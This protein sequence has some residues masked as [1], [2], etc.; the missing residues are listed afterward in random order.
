MQDMTYTI[1]TDL[2]SNNKSLFGIPKLN[3]DQEYAKLLDSIQKTALSSAKDTQE[4]IDNGR[5]T[6]E[7]GQP[8][9]ENSFAL[10]KKITDERDEI[11]KKHD[12]YI[13]PYSIEC[14]E[15]NN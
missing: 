4:L 6:P 2:T 10:W 1:L 14:D 13:K 5:I 11:R 12:E 9:I 7:Q 15:S 8:I 3:K